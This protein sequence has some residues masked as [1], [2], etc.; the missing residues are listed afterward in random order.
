[1]KSKILITA[2]LAFLPLL[3]AAQSYESIFKTPDWLKDHLNDKDLIILHV[4]SKS[5]YDSAHIPGA[6][7]IKMSEFVTSTTDSIYTEMPT[8]TYLDS[9][10]QA[11]GITNE[12]KVILYYGGEMFAATFRLYFTFDYLGLAENVFILDGGLKTWKNGGLPVS[13]DNVALPVAQG[14]LT[15][16][17]NTSLIARKEQVRNFVGAAEVKIIDARR[18]AYY[19]GEKDGDGHYKRPGHIASAKNITWLNIVD[20]NQTLK[21]AE[22]LHE[23]FNGQGI[24]KGDK[25]ITYCHVGL[26]A[27]VLY[28]ISKRLGHDVK[29][30]DGSYNEW[31][32]LDDTYPVENTFK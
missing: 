2:V 19:S 22:K 26:R 10:L 23:Y 6:Q 5:N 27:S 29:M 25:I 1:M 3:I 8:V 30:Y 4:E 32:R 15:I 18:D 17:A 14:T 24:N 11:R 7:F 20:E 21:S 12:S 31:D 9:L 13:A 28:T 16:T